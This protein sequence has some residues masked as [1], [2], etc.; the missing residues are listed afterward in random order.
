MIQNDTSN[1]HTERY[2]NIL[3]HRHLIYSINTHNQTLCIIMHQSMIP[4]LHGIRILTNVPDIHMD[5][6]VHCVSLATNIH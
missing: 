4:S 1:T 2:I 3:I 5:L 6:W